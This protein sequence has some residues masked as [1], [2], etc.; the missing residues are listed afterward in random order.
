VAWLAVAHH[1]PERTRLRCPVL[2]RNAAACTELADAL[3]AVPGVR[4][5]KVRPYTGSALILHDAGVAV[6]A[7]TEAASRA[8]G[9]ARVLA[10]GEAPPLSTAVPAFSSIRQK[11]AEIAR[12]IDRDIRRGT[13]GSVDLGTLA[14]LGM[15]GAGAAGVVATGELQAPPWFN[16][17]WWAYRTFMT[18]QNNA[19]PPAPPA[20]AP[21]P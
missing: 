20:D 7:L 13:E 17:A 6:A 15:V 16:L 5:V 1:L 19:A 12:E 10:P 9:G 4:E 14:T 18:T 21:P 3:A 11:M 2:R 8:L